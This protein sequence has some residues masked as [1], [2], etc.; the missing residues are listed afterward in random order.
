MSMK[1]KWNYKDMSDV[2]YGEEIVYQKAADFLGDTV[3]DWGCGTGWARR[4]FTNYKGIDGSLGFVTETI[5]LVDYTSDVENI[6]IRQV[7]EH[8]HDW[9][10]ILENAYKSFSKKLCLTIHTPLADE[11]KVITRNESDI[12]DIS[13]KLQDLKDCFPNCKITEEILLTKFEY[14]TELILYIEK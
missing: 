9:K 2:C 5:D 8:N 10:K 14:A 4:Y 1:Y 3:E 11:T 7:I 12:P 6:L 13:F